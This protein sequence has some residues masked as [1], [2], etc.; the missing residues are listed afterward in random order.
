MKTVYRGMR[1]ILFERKHFCL[2]NIWFND[3]CIPAND[4]QDQK[5]PAQIPYTL[6][7]LIPA[8]VISKLDKLVTPSHLMFFAFTVVLG[9]GT[10]VT[11][12]PAIPSSDS[13]AFLRSAV[14]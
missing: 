10:M 12:T 3:A 14:L 5:F 13:I 6:K 1:S 4:V 7:A 8:A 2:S 9:T 11:H